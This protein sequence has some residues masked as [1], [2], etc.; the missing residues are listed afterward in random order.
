L[1]S[2]TETT[3]TSSKYQ[4]ENSALTSHQTVSPQELEHTLA[5][6]DLRNSMTRNTIPY[7]VYIIMAGGGLLSFVVICT[8]SLL[9]GLY[10]YKSSK[11]KKQKAQTK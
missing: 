2:I 10:V 7:Y 1:D 3:N 5:S 4:S 6:G 11:T 9:L 8:L